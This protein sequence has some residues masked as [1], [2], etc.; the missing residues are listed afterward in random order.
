LIGPLQALPEHA[1]LY[2]GKY[3]LFL[4]QQV[5]DVIERLLLTLHEILAQ[6]RASILRLHLWELTLFV[7]A[8]GF[9]QV[10]LALLPIFVL[11][12]LI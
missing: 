12:I 2:L 4:Q 1:F 6:N 3:L 8:L 9:L 5:I 7:L 11:L 10:A